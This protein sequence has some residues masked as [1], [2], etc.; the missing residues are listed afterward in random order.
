MADC[1]NSILDI[2]LYP[3]AFKLPG[4]KCLLMSQ[5]AEAADIHSPIA[6]VPHWF[7]CQATNASLCLN[8]Q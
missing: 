7:S 5:S 6:S 4:D 8:Q 2:L 3:T 1:L